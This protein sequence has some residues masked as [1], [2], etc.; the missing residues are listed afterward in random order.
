MKKG[1]CAVT[2]DI[3]HEGH[4]N[5]INKCKLMCDFLTVGI[6]SDECVKQYK[7]AYPIFNQ[8]RR[9]VIV[10]NLKTVDAVILQEQFE[11]PILDKD[12]I[13]FDSIEHKRQGTDCYI[14]KTEGVSSS[15]IKKII[16]CIE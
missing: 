11:F 9:L 12:T 2:A 4:I 8:Y 6:M 3:L 5:F 1:Y 16:S 7:G 14:P 10:S 15:D 13:I